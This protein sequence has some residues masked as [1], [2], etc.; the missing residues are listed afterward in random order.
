MISR[1]IDVARS[2][3]GL[4]GGCIAAMMQL[5]ISRCNS[6]GKEVRNNGKKQ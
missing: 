1:A 6:L 5:S 3:F 4:T 2:I